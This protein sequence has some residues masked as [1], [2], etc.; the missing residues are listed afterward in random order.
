MGGRKRKGRGEER[1]KGI[2]EGEKRKGRGEKG[3]GEEKS[4]IYNNNII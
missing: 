2:R 4:I 3:K 1:R